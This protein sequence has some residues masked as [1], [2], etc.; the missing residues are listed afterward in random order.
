MG[1]PAKSTGEKVSTRG[2]EAG[3]AAGALDQERGQI[4]HCLTLTSTGPSSIKG[5]QRGLARPHRLRPSDPDKFYEQHGY[6][7]GR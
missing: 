2:G 7:R 1:F 4:L 6:R 3:L 5:N